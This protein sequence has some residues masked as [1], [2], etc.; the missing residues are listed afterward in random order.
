VGELA[1]IKTAAIDYAVA[2]EGLQVG[3][4]WATPVSHEYQSP[5]PFSG[6]LKT[7]T[8]EYTK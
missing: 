6:T 4:N 3:R 5:F 7:V 2:A 8:V 1:D